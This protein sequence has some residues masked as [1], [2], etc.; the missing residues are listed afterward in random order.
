M[1]TIDDLLALQGDLEHT[2]AP[3]LRTLHPSTVTL[4]ELVTKPEA[5]AMR[6]SAPWL[7]IDIVRAR[8]EALAAFFGRLGTHPRLPRHTRL[9]FFQPPVPE[10]DRKEHE[11]LMEDVWYRDRF[12]TFPMAFS[13]LHVSPKWLSGLS[14]SWSTGNRRLLPLGY[15]YVTQEAEDILGREPVSIEEEEIVRRAAIGH[16]VPNVPTLL[17][18]GNDTATDYFLRGIIH[19]IGHRWLPPID[20]KSDSLHNAVMLDAIGTVNADHESPWETMVHRE[21][22]DPYFY[23]DGKRYLDACRGLPLDPLQAYLLSRLRRWYASPTHLAKR[24]QLWDIDLL[25]DGAQARVQ[26]RTVLEEMHGDGFLRYKR[27][28]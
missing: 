10:E 3:F 9:V 1:K 16:V 24:S 18:V 27:I 19:D 13:R 11:R 23:V 22:T 2:Y 7:D 15:G 5:S 26:M 25:W 17:G 12:G 20:S 21:C 14:G 4:R 6:L 28:V 8:F